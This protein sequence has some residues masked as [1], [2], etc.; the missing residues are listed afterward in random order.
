[1]WR[2]C[3]IASLA[4]VIAGT[5]PIPRVDL[6]QLSQAESGRLFV[7]YCAS[8]HGRSGRG[9]GPMAGNLRV[10]P[11]NLTQLARKNGGLFPRER[12]RRIIDGRDVSSH[13]TG[14]MPVWGDAFTKREGLTEAAARARID[15]LVRYL[16]SLQ[17]RPGQ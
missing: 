12:A 8:C 11:A 10:A 16:D 6:A 14:E 17:E 1:M 7:T 2:M 13:G 15:A 4:A 3:E 5:P 9:D